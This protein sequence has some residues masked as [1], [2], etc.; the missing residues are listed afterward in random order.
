MS[1]SSKDGEGSNLETLNMAERRRRKVEEEEEA[2]A[3]VVE[4][5]DLE[6][7]E[8]IGLERSRSGS[9]KARSKAGGKAKGAA[10]ASLSPEKKKAGKR[11]AG[12]LGRL[13]ARVQGR[14]AEEDRKLILENARAVLKSGEKRKGRGQRAQ[15][16]LLEQ[17]LVED[18][19]ALLIAELRDIVAKAREFMSSAEAEGE[20]G[21]LEDDEVEGVLQDVMAAALFYHQQAG[22][23][24]RM[25]EAERGAL[26]AVLH[27]VA[28]L[29]MGAGERQSAARERL[30]RVFSPSVAADMSGEELRA[31]IKAVLGS[32]RMERLSA[33][34]RSSASV[35][36]SEEGAHVLSASASASRARRAKKDILRGQAARG[37]RSGDRASEVASSGARSFLATSEGSLRSARS[38]TRTSSKS[39][40]MVETPESQMQE[41]ARRLSAEVGKRA[42]KQV[43]RYGASALAVRELSDIAAAY[44][45]A[46]SARERS[47]LRVEFVVT[48][49]TRTPGALGAESRAK[50]GRILKAVFPDADDVD[51][52]GVRDLIAAKRAH[53]RVAAAPT[54]EFPKKLQKYLLKHLQRMLTKSQIAGVI[55]EG[56]GASESVSDSRTPGSK[57]SRTS[58][59]SSS[60]RS[61]SPLRSTPTAT[62][63]Q[64]KSEPGAASPPS[65]A[66]K[67]RRSL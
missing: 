60:S 53:P 16:R 56:E 42:R 59:S 61:S 1:R 10:K 66:K 55:E 3:D 48:L 30:M 46:K 41:L 34:L 22:P 38:A 62:P 49:F 2:A 7:A 28:P 27:E 6:S 25:K 8:E 9:G 64:T 37:S 45:R 43:Q 51:I 39:A 23:R 58:R 47:D 15:R 18:A 17:L 20:G 12:M 52:E 14:D 24:R 33:A 4:A 26:R 36:A 50:L 35:A 13:M 65:A 32:A 5:M 67:K 40:E 11:L 29:V 21:Y 31:R 44:K 19:P 57:G 63:S 54:A